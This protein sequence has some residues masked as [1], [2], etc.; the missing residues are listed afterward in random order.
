MKGEDLII[1]I[2][3]LRAIAN[4]VSLEFFRGNNNEQ[5]KI[6]QSPVTIADC[7]IEELWR[8]SIR[9]KFPEHGIIGEEY[10]NERID[11]DFKW[12]MDPIDGTSSFI[13][14]RPIF[15]NLLALS[16]KNEV[17][18]GFMNQPINQEYWLGLTPSQYNNDWQRAI[19]IESEFLEY[20]SWLNNKKINTRDCVNISDAVI[21]SSSPHYFKGENKLI[22]E[23][24]SKVAKYQKVGG[25]IYGGDCYSYASLA[26]GFVD[27]VIDPQ[28]KIYDYASLIPIIKMAGGSITNWQGEELILNESLINGA[29]I[30]IIATS[31]NKL[32]ENIIKFIKNET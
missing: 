7:R 24:I 18:L 21:C 22:L 3:E 16:Y 11:A 12:I 23:K 27:I 15:G 6:D 20:G 19:G 31:N 1:F 5:I 13:I 9:K 26:S 17:I 8:E 10:G 28:M 30:D 25:V 29:S 32:S 4:R 14:G 2:N